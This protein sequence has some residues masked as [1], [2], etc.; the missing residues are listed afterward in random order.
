MHEWQE[1][2]GTT[3]LSTGFTKLDE[4]TSGLQNGDLIIIAGRPS[5]GKT[6]LAMNIVGNVAIEQRKPV[7]VFS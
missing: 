2:T 6:S 4:L 5:M 3:G 1:N 7:V